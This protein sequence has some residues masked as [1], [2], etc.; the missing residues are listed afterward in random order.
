MGDC[1]LDDTSG[2]YDPVQSLHQCVVL[3]GK[4]EP[5]VLHICYLHA[6][7][8]DDVVLTKHL[9]PILSGEVQNCLVGRQM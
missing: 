5:P 3:R 2:S 4:E 8:Q 9:F 6:L 1:D 7:L